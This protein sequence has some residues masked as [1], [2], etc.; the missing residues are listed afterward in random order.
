MAHEVQDGGNSGN[1]QRCGTLGMNRAF[2]LKAVIPKGVPQHTGTE[3]FNGQEEQTFLHQV[4]LE[5]AA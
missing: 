5:N 3:G 4:S 2:I 1:W